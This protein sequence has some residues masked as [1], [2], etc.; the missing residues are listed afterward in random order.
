MSEY[1]PLWLEG[2]SWLNLGEIQEK[3]VLQ[4]RSGVAFVCT[5]ANPGPE[6]GVRLGT[7]QK[8]DISPGISISVRTT[9]DGR[10]LITR[11]AFGDEGGASSS[12]SLTQ[13]E[14]NQATIIANQNSI[15][16]RLI[17]IESLLVG[18]I[19]VNILSGG[20]GL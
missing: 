7:D 20:G 3:I 9:E 14:I 19:G 11:E 6:S 10:A 1:G 15:N 12:S 17:S 13:I 8:I 18:G 5:S 16:Q 2:S 4:C